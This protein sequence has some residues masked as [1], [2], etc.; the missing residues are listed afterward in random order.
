M[1]NFVPLLTTNPCPQPLHLPSH[2][3]VKAQTRNSSNL[4]RKD[5]V[6]VLSPQSVPS[7]WFS[8]LP[9]VGCFMPTHILTLAAGSSWF[10]TVDRQHGRGDVEKHDTPLQPF[11]C[12][13][14]LRQ[15][16][17]PFCFFSIFMVLIHFYRDNSTGEIL[18]VFFSFH[19]SLSWKHD[20][21][22]ILSLLLVS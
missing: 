15:K 13:S 21:I 22:F 10:S 4:S 18:K 1:W 16:N 2:H 11:T 5:R 20:A 17:F 9:F 14:K 8:S 6:Q 7:W 19:F 3:L 12:E